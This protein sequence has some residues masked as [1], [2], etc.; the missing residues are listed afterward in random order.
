MRRLAFLLGLLLLVGCQSVYDSEA[1][2]LAYLRS[3]SNPSLGQFRRRNELEA[4]IAIEHERVMAEFE[5]R[6]RVEQAKMDERLADEALARLREADTP[7]PSRRTLMSG[8]DDLAARYPGTPAG[9]AAKARAVELHAAWDWIYT[10][11]GTRPKD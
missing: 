8:Y 2:E 9:R 5:A 10:K 7:N 4:K 6:E 1:E 11:D 3:L